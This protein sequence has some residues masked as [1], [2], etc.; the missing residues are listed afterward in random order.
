MTAGRERNNSRCHAKLFIYLF[1]FVFQ[2]R[3]RVIPL[4]STGLAFLLS[5][6]SSPVERAWIN[7]L[8]P[9]QQDIHSPAQSRPP[10]Q[11]K[12]SPP[13]CAQ[14]GRARFKPRSLRQIP[15]PSQITRHLPRSIPNPFF[16]HLSLQNTPPSARARILFL[17]IIPADKTKYNKRDPVPNAQNELSTLRR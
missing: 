12:Q 14:H 5:L 17:F 16:S 7:P 15:R 4:R 11:E 8:L 9:A 3:K 1:N 2:R 13:F 6:P 10:S